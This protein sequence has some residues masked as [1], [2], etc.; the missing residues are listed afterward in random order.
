VEADARDGV[1]LTG[2]DRVTIEAQDD[3]EV[4]LVDAR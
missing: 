4:V 2:L 1:A 3:A